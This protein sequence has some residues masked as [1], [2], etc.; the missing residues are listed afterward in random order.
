MAWCRQATNHYLTQYWVISISPYGIT[1]LQY[2]ATREQ[3]WLI[4]YYNCVSFLQKRNLLIVLLYCTTRAM[5]AGR[6]FLQNQDILSVLFETNSIGFN[7]LWKTENFY[8]QWVF[9]RCIFS[10][11]SLNK[12]KYLKKNI[13]IYIIYDFNDTYK[14]RACHPRG[15]YLNYFPGTLSWNQVTT[16]HLKI[17]HP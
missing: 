11:S 16:T 6:Y 4:M 15:H 13:I 7:I 17:R 1:R 2:L 10:F 12:L 5:S 3:R 14:S 8:V 9:W